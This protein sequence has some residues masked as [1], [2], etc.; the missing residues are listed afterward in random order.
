[1]ATHSFDP[2]DVIIT[3]GGFPIGGFADGEFFSFERNNDAYAMTVGADGD[4][5]RVKSNDRSGACTLTLDQTSNS[6]AVLS[7][8]AT[9]DELSNSGIVPVLVKEINGTTTLFSGNGWVQKLPV[10]SYGKETTT[11]VWVIAMA[12]TQ[13]FV[14]GNAA[15]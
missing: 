2:K 4:T 15:V 10:V 8:F 7:G 3:V 12:E 14:G 11:R 6:N 13:V 5:T 1:M 9:A